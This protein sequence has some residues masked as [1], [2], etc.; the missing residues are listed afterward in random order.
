MFAALPLFVYQGDLTL[1]A[2][3]LQP[4]LQGDVLVEFTAAG[5]VLIAGVGASLLFPRRFRM[6]N[7]LPAMPWVC[8][9]FPPFH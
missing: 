4:W 7:L 2:G 5:D 9:L 8:I 3:F 1:L 6:L